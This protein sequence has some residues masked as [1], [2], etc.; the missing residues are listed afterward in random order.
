M[1]YKLAFGLAAVF[2]LAGTVTH[3]QT[4][5]SAI[6]KLTNFPSKLFSR[7]NGQTASLNQQLTRQTEKYLQRMARKEAKLRAQ[8]YKADSAK[9]AALYP[10]DPQQQYAALL[11]KF[12]QDS[13]RVF[14]S[15]GP[16]YLPHVDSLQGML[17]FLSL[18]PSALNANPAQLA[19]LQSSLAQFQQLQARLQAADAV[20]QFI[21][22]RKAQIQQYLSGYSQLPSGV[23]NTLQGY[24]KGSLLLCGAGPGVPSDA[25]RSG[26]DD[27]NSAW[28]VEQ[29]SC[30]Q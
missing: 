14:T 8:L 24:N 18:N 6:D 21:Q 25:K 17:K 30:V 1:F 26:Q 5:D 23:G 15:M 28:L 27:P 11:Q 10:N 12:R 22:S 19:A 2:C 4:V 3:A 20:K 16:E 29:A 7:I 13:S 9:A